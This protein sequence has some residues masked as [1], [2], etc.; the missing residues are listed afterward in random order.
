MASTSRNAAYYRKHRL[1]FERA[2]R[3]GITPA[4]AAQLIEHEERM[5]RLQATAEEFERKYGPATAPFRKWDAAHMLR[6]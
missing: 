5:A 2:Q 3:G 1:A 4:E 6:N